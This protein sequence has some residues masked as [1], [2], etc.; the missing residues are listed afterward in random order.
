MIGLLGKKVRMTQV[1]DDE[2]NPVPVTVVEAGPCI[3]TQV[4]SE[5]EPEKKA[6]QL[7]YLKV[8][9][10][11]L[12]L[13]QMGFFK[14]NE[15]PVMKY[16]KDFRLE[17]DSGEYEKGQSLTVEIFSVGDRVDVVG[18]TKGRG[19]QGVVKRWGFAGYPATHGSKDKH[20]VPG[21]M[22]PGT[23]PGR[24]WKNKKLPGR[25]GNDRMT[26]R[27]LKV[28]KIVPEKNLIFLRGA[29]P[30]SRGSLVTIRTKKKIG[31]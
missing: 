4:R 12:S 29:I 3:V 16:L 15:L 8:K 2:G 23:S 22:G 14:K 27:N 19:F 5:E 9:E 13:P 10:D 7:G 28:I 6:L 21:S 30:G 31:D 25:Y 18:K 17:D 20:R 26:V 11:K 24:V 1:F